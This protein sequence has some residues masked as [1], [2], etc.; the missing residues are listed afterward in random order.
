MITRFVKTFWF[1]YVHTRY[2]IH[3]TIS[4]V[5]KTGFRVIK[6]FPLGKWTRTEACTVNF[7]KQCRMVIYT[8]V[9]YKL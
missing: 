3:I 5:M 6:E 8:Q 9:A 4:N 7:S 1:V 2:G